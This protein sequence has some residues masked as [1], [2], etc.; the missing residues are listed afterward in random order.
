MS[1]ITPFLNDLVADLERDA[2]ARA[3]VKVKVASLRKQIAAARLEA[4]KSAYQMGHNDTVEGVYG[5]PEEAVQELCEELDQED[6]R[7]GVDHG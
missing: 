3:G 7:G 6:G 4:A 5:D 1:N 2:A